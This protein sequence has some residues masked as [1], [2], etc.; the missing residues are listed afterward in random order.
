MCIRGGVH[1]CGHAAGGG[2]FVVLWLLSAQCTGWALRLLELLDRLARCAHHGGHPSPM[3]ALSS[4]VGL[5]S[6]RAAWL[7]WG[8]WSCLAATSLQVRPGWRGVGCAARSEEKTRKG[9]R[10]GKRG[11]G[12][13]EAERRQR[14]AV[15]EPG[16]AQV[17]A[18]AAA[19]QGCVDAP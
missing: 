1:G 10:G 4:R 6:R 12:G 9:R 14:A 16:R 3:G 2:N 5:G 7:L 13:G 15:A 8:G 19:A 17:S 11:G 18:A